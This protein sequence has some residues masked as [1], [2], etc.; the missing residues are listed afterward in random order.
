MPIIQSL[1]D[2]DLYKFFMCQIIF[3]RYT[4]ASA[5]YIY[6]LRNDD[7]H[8]TEQMYNK[9]Q[10]EIDELCN[11][12]YTDKELT[13]LYSTGYFKKDFI[14]F[15]GMFKLNRK[16]LDV[17]LVDGKLDIHIK[18]SW[19]YIMM[20]EI[21]LMEI[22]SEVYFNA[23]EIVKNTYNII[24]NDNINEKI[25]QITI[26]NHECKYECIDKKF[27]KLADFGGRRRRSFSWH[28][29]IVGKLKTHLPLNFVGTSNVY[30]AMKHK[31]KPIG[32]MAHE[33]IMAFQALG[34]RLINS[35][36]VA[37]EMWAKEYRGNLGIAL[38]DTINMDAFLNDFD[39]YYCKLFDGCRH[40]SGDP[41]VWCNKLIAH[42]KKLGIDPTTK[43]AVFSDGLNITKAIAIHREFK[44][45]I[46]VSFGIGTNLT[47]DVGL[48]PLNHVIKIIKCND[49][50]VAKISDSSGK[51]VC[52][53]D[54]YVTYLKSVFGVV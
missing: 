16:H 10:E 4:S 24:G 37:L 22:I 7:I 36:R 8:F 26:Y 42:Y 44:N 19:L 45:Q 1:L 30:M 34:C 43:T 54:S 31:I 41:Y 3:H 32:T 49:Q 21:Y 25:T 38:T 12:K 27:L 15:L 52:T 33:Y 50:D 11:L 5:E 2:S 39:L 9:I 28:D 48:I 46:N 53:N 14:E 47:N 29:H 51:T 20:F 17:K 40:D 18:G 35:Q 23:I 13:Y 6:K